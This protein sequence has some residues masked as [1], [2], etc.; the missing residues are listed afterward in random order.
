[1]EALKNQKNREKSFD[2]EAQRFDKKSMDKAFHIIRKMSIDVEAQTWGS[3][4]GRNET[5]KEN[6]FVNKIFTKISQ[7]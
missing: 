6:S 7:S 4:L 1:M 3:S 2:V 5:F